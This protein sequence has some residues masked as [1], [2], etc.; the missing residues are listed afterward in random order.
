MFLHVASSSNNLFTWK[1]TKQSL[2]LVAALDLYWESFIEFLIGCSSNVFF[3]WWQ[4]DYFAFQSQLY[5]YIHM[6]WPCFCWFH[7]GLVLELL[8]YHS[9]TTTQ[10]FTCLLNYILQ[11]IIES[12][13]PLFLFGTI[14]F[15]PKLLKSFQLLVYAN[16]LANAFWFH[17]INLQLLQEHS[18][19]LCMVEYLDIIA[20]KSNIESSHSNDGDNSSLYSH[21]F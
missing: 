21:T 2:G 17:C 18:Y 20:Y 5:L 1:E 3:E 16:K 19:N 14:H 4:G 15:P 11:V 10:D 7:C 8:C 9:T 12:T 13:K 6:R